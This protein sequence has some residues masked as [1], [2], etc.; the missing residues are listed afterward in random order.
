[1]DLNKIKLAFPVT[2]MILQAGAW[3][4]CAP[5]SATNNSAES[6]SE[7]FRFYTPPNFLLYSMQHFEAFYNNNHSGR[8]LFWLYHNSSGN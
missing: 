6:L 3:P 7:D 4:L 8:K 2:L 5:L 1:M